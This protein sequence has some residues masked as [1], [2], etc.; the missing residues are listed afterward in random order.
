MGVI[1]RFYYTARLGVGLTLECKQSVSSATRGVL[2]HIVTFE[3]E[4]IVYSP[5]P[6]IYGSLPTL[7][8]VFA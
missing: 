8:A 4:K 1:F 3:H 6:K 2:L 5:D 7:I